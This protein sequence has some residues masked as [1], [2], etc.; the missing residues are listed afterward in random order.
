[1]NKIILLL[2]LPN[3][4]QAYQEDFND[5][6]WYAKALA[7]STVTQAAL[8][9]KETQPQKT[10]IWTKPLIIDRDNPDFDGITSF[11]L[12]CNIIYKPDT[13]Y[14]YPWIY[15]NYEAAIIINKDNFTID[16]NGYN[17]SLQAP[18][19][20]NFLLNNPTY[21]ISLYQGVKNTRIISSA[22]HGENAKIYKGSITNFTGY[23]IFASGSQKSYN[24]YDVYSLL[25]K[26]LLIDN[27][28][29]TQNRNGIYIENALRP[30]IT[31]TDIIYNYSPQI[32]YGIYYSYILNGLIDSCNINQNWSYIDTY[33][34][35]LQDT[36]NVTVQNSQTNANRSLRSGNV[37]G[38]LL[39]ASPLSATSSDNTISNCTA[40]RNLC[41]NVADKASIG[42]YINNISRHNVIE[43]C[44]SLNSG[45]TN[46]PPGQ[47]DPITPPDGIG[48][49]I[50]SSDFNNITKNTAG[51]HATYGFYDSSSLSTSFF[52]ANT[53]MFNL[54]NFNVI[55]PNRSGIGS[56]QLATT[57]LYLN[58]ISAFTG[59]GPQ[60]TNLSIQAT[61]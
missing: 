21:G 25:I 52:T 60:L 34:M 11:T 50:E 44:T 53:S 49:K 48:F 8:T 28:L 41:A 29:I 30:I 20:S 32:L 37:T 24:S 19:S 33:G 18:A 40:N 1:M 23:A 22:R 39:T 58:D 27:L 45:H 13:L 31:N 56:G 16:F 15:R 51:Y 12:P 54:I 57:N 10:I 43:N 46:T 38:I 61:E 7:T 59:A 35:Y 3:L 47:A 9:A 5:D 4:M 55:V 14:V 36:T 26:N 2:L 42:F 17:L 6:A